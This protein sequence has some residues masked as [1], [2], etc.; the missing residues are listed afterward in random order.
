MAEESGLAS[1]GSFH[2]EIHMLLP[3]F[4]WNKEVDK[5]KAVMFR[6]LYDDV[7]IPEILGLSQN[8][9]PPK[10]LVYKIKIC[11]AT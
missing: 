9:D 10:R 1:L 3:G 7:R 6:K 5:Y 11:V 8:N 2:W 4:T